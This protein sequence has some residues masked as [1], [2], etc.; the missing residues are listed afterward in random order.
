MAGYQPLMANEWLY[1]ANVTIL[2]K[3]AMEIGIDI[4]P[5]VIHWWLNNPKET[6]NK[7]QGN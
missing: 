6:I 5:T 4:L 3:K 1:Y 2:N 7:I